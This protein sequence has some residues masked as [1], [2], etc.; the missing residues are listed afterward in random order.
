MAA[1]VKTGLFRKRFLRLDKNIH[2]P[3]KYPYTYM[4][5]DAI[6]CEKIKINSKMFSKYLKNS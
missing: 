5:F 2:Q 1:P 3:E 4:P 6:K